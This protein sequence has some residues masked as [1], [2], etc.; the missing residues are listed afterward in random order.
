MTNGFCG[1]RVRVDNCNQAAK[2]GVSLHGKSDFADH[3]A[4]P[5]SNYGCAQNLVRRGIDAEP[6]QAL[7]GIIGDRAVVAL[8]VFFQ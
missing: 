6:N 3:V 8:E 5:V 7:R 2:A 1:G 4:G